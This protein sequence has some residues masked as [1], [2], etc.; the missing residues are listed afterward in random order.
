MTGAHNK[1]MTE[2]YKLSLREAAQ[3]IR[4][5]KLTGTAYAHALLMRIASREKEIQA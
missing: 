4:S 1:N 5:G 2:L 3:R